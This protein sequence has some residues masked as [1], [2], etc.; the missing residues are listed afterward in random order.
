[1]SYSPLPPGDVEARLAECVDAYQ[2]Y[3]ET[4]YDIATTVRAA[5]IDTAGRHPG[6]KGSGNT[7][8]AYEFTHAGQSLGCRPLCLSFSEREKDSWTGAD[9]SLLV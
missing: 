3:R 7:S 4:V 5:G 1:M 2:T 6:Y 9:R 8:S